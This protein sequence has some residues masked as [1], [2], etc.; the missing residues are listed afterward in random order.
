MGRDSHDWQSASN[1]FTGAGTGMPADRIMSVTWNGRHSGAAELPF[2]ITAPSQ[3][4]FGWDP[5]FG[6][7]HTFAGR[8]AVL[9]LPEVAPN[10]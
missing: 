1:G 5:T 6:S 9:E 3:I 7:K 4:H 2:L 10:D 8:I